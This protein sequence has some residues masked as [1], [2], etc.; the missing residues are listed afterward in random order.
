MR[1]G[2]TARSLAAAPATAAAGG[3][4]RD[5]PPPPF[6]HK[7]GEGHVPFHGGDYYDA[8]FNKRN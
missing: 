6:D 2:C 7:T 5:L 3:R 8:R 4:A 1:S